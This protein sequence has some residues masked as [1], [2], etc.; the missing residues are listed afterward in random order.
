MKH[1]G[2]KEYLKENVNGFIDKVGRKN[3]IIQGVDL[4]VA[5]K[6]DSGER[7]L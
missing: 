2:N 3:D 7:C 5:A 4:R 6:L 1:T